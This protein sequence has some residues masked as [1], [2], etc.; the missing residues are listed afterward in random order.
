MLLTFSDC[1]FPRCFV[2]RYD[3]MEAVEVGAVC[4]VAGRIISAPEGVRG[5]PNDPLVFIPVAT[6][7]FAT[8]NEEYSS[9]PE[10]HGASQS[11]PSKLRRDKFNSEPFATV[12]SSPDSCGWVLLISFSCSTQ[13]G[14]FMACSTPTASCRDDIDK[15]S[16][17]CTDQLQKC[18]L[19]AQDTAR[20]VSRCLGRWVKA[21]EIQFVVDM[22]QRVETYTRC[23]IYTNLYYDVCV[24]CPSV[25]MF[26]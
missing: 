20:W 8:S 19:S 13:Y 6:T 10:G 14:K 15:T 24:A 17:M 18:P 1:F 12:G 3:E 7:N 22:R 2:A 21:L 25:Y 4:L 11:S 16:D 26:C 5:H 23:V 9:L